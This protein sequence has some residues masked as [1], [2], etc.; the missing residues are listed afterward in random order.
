[1][2][3]NTGASLASHPASKAWPGQRD[4]RSDRLIGLFI[5][6]LLPALFWTALIAVL[7][8][9]IGLDLSATAIAGIGI[10][11]GAFLGCVCC[12]VIFRPAEQVA[13]PGALLPRSDD[14]R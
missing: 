11:I 2:R 14:R 8:H 1:M 3:I 5:M 12:A 4:A 10:V 7:A 6:A 13:H 9:W